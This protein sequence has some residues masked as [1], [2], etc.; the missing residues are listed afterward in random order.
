VVC[1]DV[2]STTSVTGQGNIFLAEAVIANNGSLELAWGPV[3]INND[4]TQTDRWCPAI[5]VEPGG[6][7]L[8][9]GYYSRQ[10]DPTNNSLIMAYG[11]KGDVANGLAN[12]TFYCFPISPTQFP[13]LFAGSNS[14][15]SMQY[16]PVYAAESAAC[17]DA[18]AIIRCFPTERPVSCQCANTIL[19]SFGN[20][21][22]FQ[23]DNTWAAA[24]SNYFYYAWCD[25]SRTWT[26]VIGGTNYTT[27]A[28]ADVKLAK[29]LQ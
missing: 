14:V 1:S 29:I 28:D 6:T 13:P 25:R 24:D 2:P 19:G 12:A 16:D 27:R 10:N 22:W 8:F 21:N 23:D 18:Y 11:A 5:T 20:A 17:W 3:R 7:E 15:A 9:I 4:G 26:N